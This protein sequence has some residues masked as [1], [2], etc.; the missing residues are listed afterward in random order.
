MISNRIQSNVRSVLCQGGVRVER[1]VVEF[2]I[3]S[4]RV[5]RRFSCKVSCRQDLEP[6]QAVRLCL[7]KRRCV[8]K[9]YEVCY[10]LCRLMLIPFYALLSDYGKY[11][12]GKPGTELEFGR[13]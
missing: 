13:K 3:V 9:L 1:A 10:M 11:Q 7:S 2:Q 12:G 6:R 5:K 4:C 8:R